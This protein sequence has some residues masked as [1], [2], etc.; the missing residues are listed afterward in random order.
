MVGE[1]NRRRFMRASGTA[2]GLAAVPGMAS[3]SERNYESYLDIN[4]ESFIEDGVQYTAS[5]TRNTKTGETDGVIL[6]T[7]AN[8]GLS[9]PSQ[10][11]EPLSSDGAGMYQISNDVLEDLDASAFKANSGDAVTASSS[12]N[13]ELWGQLSEAGGV[14]TESNGVTIQEEK[15]L[16]KEAARRISSGAKDGINRIGAYYIDSPKGTDCDAVIAEGPHRQFGAAIDY[17][18][19]VERYAAGPVGAAL[20]AIIG[21]YTKTKLGTGIG[22]AVGWILGNGAADLK[23]STNLTLILRD[24]DNCVT[25]LGKLCKNAEI[26]HFASGYFMD[27]SRELFKVPAPSPDTKHLH[28]G[29]NGKVGEVDTPHRKTY[30]ISS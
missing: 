27:E 16:L 20:G 12:N 5:V 21:S 7:R 9:A 25:P 26:D 30:R 6:P 15:S 19:Y 28:Y 4:V 3:A 17:E 1:I 2:A 23:R 18:E 11:V 14:T 24:K 22:V 13:T 10:T 8:G 29:I